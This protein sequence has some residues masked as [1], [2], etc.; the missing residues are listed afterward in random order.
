[1]IYVLD[2][3]E[4]TTSTT[5]TTARDEPVVHI[6]DTRRGA[7]D[8]PQA[9]RDLRNRPPSLPNQPNRTLLEILIKLPS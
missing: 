6:Q 4:I 1:V 5:Q 2:E 7:S 8:N 9:L 3:P